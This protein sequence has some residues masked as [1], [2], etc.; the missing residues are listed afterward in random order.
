V[1]GAQVPRRRSDAGPLLRGVQ[2]GD[3]AEAPPATQ[4]VSRLVRKRLEQPVCFLFR[5][6]RRRQKRAGAHSFY[7]VCVWLSSF[8]YMEWKQHRFQSFCSNEKKSWR[9]GI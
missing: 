6:L 5:E 1:V 2:A 4:V 8:V 3:Q 7:S 9:K